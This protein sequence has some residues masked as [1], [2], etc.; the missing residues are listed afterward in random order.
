M[1]SIVNIDKNN[2]CSIVVENWAPYDVRLERDDIIGVMETEQDELVPLMDDLISSVCLDIHNCFPKVKRK[3]LSRE[4]I[5][6]R[7]HLQV[8]EEFHE[9]YLDILCKHQ[10]TLSIDKYDLGLAKDFKHKIHL[11]TQDPVYRKQ[12]K[13]PKVH[14]QFFEQTLDEWLKLGVVKRSNSL[15]N[16]PIFCVPKKQ[17]G[18]RIVQD[19]RELNQN[20]HID[21]YSMKEITECIGDIGRANS[22]I[23]TTLDLTSG[24]W[25]MQLDEDSQQ[26]TAFTIL[27][28]GQFHCI[29]IPMG[30]LGCPA[31]FH[32]LMEGVLRDIP[33]ELVY[34]YDLLV[35]T[36]THE[37]HLQV[38]D[39]VMAWLHKYHL[40]INLEK[41]VYGNKVSYLGFTLTP[42][43]IKP[44]KNKLKAMK[45]ARP[46]TNIKTIQS[47]MGLCNFFRTHI[48]DFAL[49]TAPLFKLTRKDSGYKSVP[50]PEKAMKAFYILQKQLTSEPVMA[51]PK[52]DHQYALIT[53][54]ATGT[55]NTPGGLG[56]ILTQVD[57]EGNFNPISFA[58]RQ[59][60]DH[61]M[62][63]SP[64]LLEAAATIWGMDF[65]N[66]YLKGKRFILYTDHK[67]LEKLCHLHSKTLNQLQTALLEH[68]IVIQYKKGSNNMPADYLSRLPGTEESIA[69]ISALDPFQADLYELQ[70][71]DKI[72][73][74]IQTFR[75]TNKWPQVIPKQDQA[76]YTAMIDKLFQDKNKVVWARLN[77]FNYPRTALYLPTERKPCARPM[78]ASS[79]DKTRLKKPSLKYPPPTSGRR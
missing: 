79:E 13:I 10:D 9:R 22:T 6:Q 37:K 60:K 4:E 51:F 50:L 21:K 66:E 55:A 64:F 63:Y 58:S 32:R 35:H 59:L 12:F 40:K 23:F 27:G 38:L 69:S 29:T 70:M 67:P 24:F 30:L 75:N 74:G 39:Q 77:D 34:I 14:H 73:Q 44:G 43:G 72:L 7:C 2:I 49:I 8:P 54:A 19:F 5:R 20:S 48:K 62:N 18:L 3:R 53:N 31:S 28:K 68:D 52:S 17:G 47:F 42:D 61:Q 25:Q 56:A 1:P 78:T 16:S 76:Y 57:Q 45:D 26:L 15:Y 71:L 36:D 46:P 11:K 41:C 33:N 65:F